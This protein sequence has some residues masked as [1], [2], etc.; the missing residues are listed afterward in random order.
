MG[1]HFILQGI[2]SIKGSNPDLLH[3]RQIL[4]HPS[5]QGRP[6]LSLVKY[7]QNSSKIFCCLVTQVKSDIFVTPWTPL[8][9]GFSRQEYWGGLPFPT[10]RDIFNSGIELRSPVSLL[11]WRQILYPWATWENISK[12][13]LYQFQTV[14]ICQFHPINIL[15][16]VLGKIMFTSGRNGQCILWIYL[17]G[18]TITKLLYKT[19]FALLF[20]N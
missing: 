4:Y 10:S 1:S 6:L 11:H 13:A 18:K 5:H 15:L 20:S 3:C 12:T 19:A 9:V 16:T 8:S 7:F 2:F 17:D 14:L